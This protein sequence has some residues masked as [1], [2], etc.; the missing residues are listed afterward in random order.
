[1]TTA[2]TQLIALLGHPVAH[3]LS[4]AMLTRAF[5]RYAIDAVYTAFDVPP[6]MLP[7][8]VRGLT[9]LGARGAN[10]TAP[11]K[12]AVLNLA[13]VVDPLARRV[14]AANVLTFASGRVHARNTDAPALVQALRVGGC[15]TR[16]ARAVVV[17]AGGA[18]RAAAV[19]LADAG[20]SVTVLARR[21]SE[22]ALVAAIVGG[23]CH[24][25]D[26]FARVRE[27]FRSASIAVQATSVGMTSSVV[28]GARA[29]RPDEDAFDAARAGVGFM[30]RGSFAMD[31]VYA[32][33]E[34]AWLA[35]AR[36][37]GHSCIDGLGMLTW[38]SAFALREW[39]GVDVAG[40]ELRA[41]LDVA[42]APE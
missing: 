34:T 24:S 39:F 25:L 10:V 31:L 12:R 14:G 41:L 4:P 3:S 40:D 2:A 29:P 32:P 42:A 36:S 22:A 8:A 38:Q 20:A 27:A 33:R 35:G 18:G 16:D 37:A 30:A 7:S 6:T 13:D 15:E 19:G 26:D 21:E 1:M 17:G 9:S 23:T 11:H 5:S 28:A